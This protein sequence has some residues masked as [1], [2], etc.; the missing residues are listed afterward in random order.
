M[1]HMAN[2]RAV[3]FHVLVTQVLDCMLNLFSAYY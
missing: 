1:L 2:R 3:Y